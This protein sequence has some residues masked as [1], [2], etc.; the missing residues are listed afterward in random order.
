M[1]EGRCPQ[2]G[3]KL[4]VSLFEVQTFTVEAS[5]YLLWLQKAAVSFLEG[6]GL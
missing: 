6:S 4:S 1:H 3:Y 2:P 5:K